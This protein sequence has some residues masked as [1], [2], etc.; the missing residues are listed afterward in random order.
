MKWPVVC[1]ASATQWICLVVVLIS[2]LVEGLGTYQLAD[3]NNVA[4]WVT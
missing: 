2:A 3:R 1:L 4:D